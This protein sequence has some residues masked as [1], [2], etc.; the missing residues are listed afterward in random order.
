MPEGGGDNAGFLLPLYDYASRALRSGQLPLWNPYLYA[1]SP[2]AA[3]VQVGL[4]YPPNV[5]LFL[6]VP[7]FTYGW[8]EAL[9]AA[10][11]FWA[12]LGLYVC[13]RCLR[14]RGAPIRRA[15][16][17][18][19]ALSFGFSDL[20]VTHF[21]N[22]NL[23][24]AASW[25]PWAFCAFH[26]A[27]HAEPG[28]PAA[29]W[30]VAAGVCVGMAGLAGHPQPFAYLLLTLGAYAAATTALRFARRP[31]RGAWLASAPARGGLAVLT[32][33]GLAA[34]A[35][36]PA[37]ELLPHTRRADL[38][39]EAA[40]EFAVAPE[41]LV[42]LF[43]PGL[44]GRGMQRYW[45]P[46]PRV[47]VGF[48]GTVALALA[49]VAVAAWVRR[50]APARGAPVAFLT[51]LAGGAFLLA[52][53]DRTPC[54]ELL[55][56]TLPSLGGLRAPARFVVLAN[57]A[58]ALLAALGLDA[59]LQAPR[60]LM[61]RV[62]LVAAVPA[63]AG[64]VLLALPGA[65]AAARLLGTEGAQRAQQLQQAAG[66]T[67]L[68]ALALGLTLAAIAAY[69]RG[70]LGPRALAGALALTAYV[71]LAVAGAGL[72][73]IPWDP[74]ANLRP[75]SMEF[76]R[77]DPGL[78]RI[79]VRPEA[80]GWWSPNAA[81]MG[82]E[83]D[84]GGV[85]NP[86]QLADYQL[87][88]ESLTDRRTR[89]Y[90]F[91]NAK[92]VVA[93]KDFALPWEKFV[94]VFDADENLAIFLNTEAMPRAQLVH[95]AL[96]AADRDAAWARVQARGFDPAVEVVV[97]G[98]R[99]LDATAAEPGQAIVT[100]YRPGAVDIVTH[101][102][103]DGYLVLADAHFPGW[104]ATV[105]GRAAPVLRAN[106]AFRAV[107]VP[108]GTHDVRFRFR[109]RSV[110]VGAVVSSVTALAAAVVWRRSSPADRR[111]RR[112]ASRSN[113]LAL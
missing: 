35:L 106:Y 23:V 10:H 28:S 57:L 18:L 65:L 43:A 40:A 63:A 85:Y 2:L 32:G 109:P 59:L 100:G 113:Q 68:F 99:R 111:A 72:D 14:T 93:P 62:L 84:V 86:L 13:A 22:A 87:Y 60:R 49:V 64:A 27:L 102:A 4:F 53:G 50:L 33:L 21:G 55:R 45:G 98:G 20:F 16:A 108:A 41:Q 92:Y 103:A 7:R 17:L 58:L 110:L 9:V 46:W 34:V 8:V 6:L 74:T 67:L 30:V 107:P 105:D 1:G 75:S 5:I 66:A 44:F 24:A 31:R 42:G 101:A 52:M 88:W 11:V 112:S 15:A 104:R 51:L 48:M 94:P 71:E 37:W 26:R 77:A 89:R 91:L 97:E 25:L 39:A 80:W 95:R 61:G 83:F 56:A 29:R 38:G 82:G 81:L 69:V 79:E 76:L 78:Y 47:E 36:V 96:P 19:G 70:R 73:R 54:L 3:D 12:A 90:D